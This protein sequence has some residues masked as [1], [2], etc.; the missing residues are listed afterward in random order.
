MVFHNKKNLCAFLFFFLVGMINVSV[1]NHKITRSCSSESGNGIVK[2][3]MT[4]YDNCTVIVLS[5]L[6]PT[7]PSVFMI[8]K[9]ITSVQKMI[10]GLR[11]PQIIISIDGLPMKKRTDENIDRLHEY[12]KELRRLYDKDQSVM[13]LPHI[14]HL[15]INNNIQDA[16]NLIDTKYIYI[17]QHDFEF[18]RTVNH[19]EII[20]EME[21][22]SEKMQIVRFDKGVGK[23]KFQNQ[24]LKLKQK[25]CDVYHGGKFNLA[26]WS[27]NN[28]LT[29]KKYYEKT[30]DIMGP[31]NRPPEGFFMANSEKMDC[32][33]GNQW[34]YDYNPGEPYLRHLDGKR[35]QAVNATIIP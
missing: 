15:H 12:T 26:R 14:K 6:I 22:Y 29:T 28:H 13:L 2:K 30:F 9:T 4:V 1:I 8:N 24:Q 19:T 3:S 34:V 7:H 10:H 23:A 17:V 20:D 5:S 25:G 21:K 18:I 16:L 33:F 27:D 32:F 35:T 11:N 31:A